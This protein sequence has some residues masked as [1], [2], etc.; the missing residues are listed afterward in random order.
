[1]FFFNLS[2]ISSSFQIPICLSQVKVL[3]HIFTNFSTTS[4]TLNHLHH[5]QFGKLEFMSMRTQSH[6]VYLLLHSFSLSP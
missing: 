2:I 5:I 3:Y 4:T 1:M 6:Q